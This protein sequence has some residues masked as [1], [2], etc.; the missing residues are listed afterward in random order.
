MTFREPLQPKM[1]STLCEA[2]HES[3]CADNH[4]GQLS[5]GNEA[6]VVCHRHGERQT[7]ALDFG[8]GCFRS[9]SIA[10]LDRRNM[11]KL[12]G[13]ADTGLALFELAIQ[14]GY[15]S[16][17]AKSD[18]PR[19]GQNWHFTAALSLSCVRFFNQ[20]LELCGQP[21]FWLH[22]SED[23]PRHPACQCEAVSTDTM[24]T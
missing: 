12:H 5:H 10:D 2:F 11:V 22:E 1:A 23:I 6:L 14:G 13:V 24:P 3:A 20:E 7:P 9:N 21:A 4:P 17:L 19:S 8:E 16:F 18:D 15:A